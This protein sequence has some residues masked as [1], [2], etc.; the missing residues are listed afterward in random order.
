MNALDD[1]VK[2][3]K[4]GGVGLSEVSANTIRQAAKYIKIVTVE[5]ELSLWC[6]DPLSNGI[7]DACYE[8]GIP[9]TA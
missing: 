6:T 5:V 9:M 1:L 4:I 7:S 8:L 3:G 2:E